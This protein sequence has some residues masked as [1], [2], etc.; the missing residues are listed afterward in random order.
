[1]SRM[2][3]TYTARG[4]NRNIST[5]TVGD[6]MRIRDNIIP[7]TAT[8]TEKNDR[9]KHLRT[10]SQNRIQNWT[11]S[12]QQAKKQRLL[13]KKKHYFEQ[14]H[15]KRKIEEEEKKL[16]EAQKHVVVERANKLLFEAQDQVKLFHGKMLMSDVMKVS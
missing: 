10:L 11:D 6:F 1:M 5:I 13:V 12:I 14:E 16:N 7:Q 8:V 9:E 3:T 15:E 2:N 4:H